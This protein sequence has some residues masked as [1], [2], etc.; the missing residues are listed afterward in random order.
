MSFT[1]AGT[2]SYLPQ[3]VVTNDDLATFLDTSDEWISTRT[4]IRSRH[5][6]VAET[7]TEMA[8]AAARA[9]LA[10]SGSAP[11][12]LDLILCATLAGEYITPSLSCMVQK[13]LGACCPAFDLN[14]ACSGFL[15][16]LDV[17]AGYFAR[18]RVK[19]VLVVCAEAMTRLIDW[20]D[21]STCVLFGDG[22]AAVVLEPGEDLLAIR[23]S[24]T[25]N[26]DALHIPHVSGNC[27]YSGYDRGPVGL[28]MNGQEVYKFAVAAMS[29]GVEKA[30]AEAGIALEDIALVI[31]HQANMRILE[32]A[33]KKL[34][35][36][37]EKIASNI[38]QCGNTSAASLPILL[39]QLNRQGRLNKGDLLA[40]T[41]FGGGLTTGACILRWARERKKAEE[42]AF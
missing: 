24:A 4:G 40:L 39:D 15:Y 33:R 18:G 13:E 42:P 22:A 23:L 6:A 12:Q 38:G 26:S 37:A 30:A 3:K 8:V 9:A 35:M 25:G 20:T 11:E 14:A 17:A 32:A 36:P 28:V 41:A 1:I 7:V 27:P 34:R 31:P 5:V 29:Q 10:D 2:G 19:K 16:A 21:R